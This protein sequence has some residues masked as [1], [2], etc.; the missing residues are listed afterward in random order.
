MTNYVASW[1]SIKIQN[2]SNYAVIK[3]CWLKHQVEFPVRAIMKYIRQG[4]G[5][6]DKL[7]RTQ[8]VQSGLCGTS[9][10]KEKVVSL[11]GK[12]ASSLLTILLLLL[13]LVRHKY[14]YMQIQ[15]SLPQ[16]LLPILFEQRSDTVQTQ[17][18]NFDYKNT[19]RKMPCNDA[20]N[21]NTNMEV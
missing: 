1:Q 17:P 4:C 11:C 21:T 18:H 3:I 10:V 16:F 20:K 7:V 2:T 5:G 9:T 13:L 6:I 19:L 8:W 14:N 15:R 12:G